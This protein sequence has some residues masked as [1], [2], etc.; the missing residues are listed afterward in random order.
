[1]NYPLTPASV[2]PRVC[3]ELERNMTISFNK[4]GSSPRVWGTHKTEAGGYCPDRFIP[5]C[6][7]NSKEGVPPTV[8]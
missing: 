6:V 4:D 3:G 1:M 5:A 7:G 8:V 2:H